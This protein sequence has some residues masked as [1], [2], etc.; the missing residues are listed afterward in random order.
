[1]N[2]ENGINRDMI[3][4]YRDRAREYDERAY[5]VE[6]RPELQKTIQA[7]T[8]ILQ[9]TLA[10]KTVLEIA[11]GT[12]YWTEKIAQTARSIEATDVNASVLDIAR[13]RQYPGRNAHFRIADLYALGNV[14]PVEALFGGFIFSHI[15]RKDYGTFLDTIQ[16]YV[17]TGGTIVLMDNNRKDSP[18]YLDRTDEQ[19]N[20]Y[21]LRT[22]ADGTKH[23]IVKNYPSQT[24]LTG[25][26]GRRVTNVDFRD[27][28][29]YWMLIYKTA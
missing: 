7:A 25:L 6:G 10:N 5:G 19:G 17:V 21:R 27:L 11:A 14:P 15:L 24:E 22:L 12:G 29:Y 4:Y 23:E 13:G 28:D 1:M 3:S 20:N 8:R 2:G 26:L 18:Q 16:R 9:E